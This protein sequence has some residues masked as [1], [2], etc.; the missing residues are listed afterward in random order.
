MTR[1]QVKALLTLTPPGGSKTNEG[2]PGKHPSDDNTPGNPTPGAG[3]PGNNVSTDKHP[4]G[5]V[6]SDKPASEDLAIDPDSSASLSPV[7][8]KT[9]ST[10]SRQQVQVASVLPQTGAVASVTGV[11]LSLLLAGLG[12]LSL[13]RKKK[14]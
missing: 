8:H 4:D 14:K 7:S 13:D 5:N 3:I 6:I 2:V 11:G 12:C 10:D 9:S 1:N